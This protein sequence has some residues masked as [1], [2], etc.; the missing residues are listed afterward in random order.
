MVDDGNVGQIFQN[1]KFATLGA[2]NMFD[3]KFDQYRPEVCPERKNKP[4]GI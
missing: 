4:I 1:P 2:Y 3:K